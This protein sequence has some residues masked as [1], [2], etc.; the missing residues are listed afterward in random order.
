MTGVSESDSWKSEILK[1]SLLGP[2]HCQ[3]RLSDLPE[4]KGRTGRVTEGALSLSP[5]NEKGAMWTENQEY[6]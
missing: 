1:D 2:N 3:M 5:W 6:F 4:A